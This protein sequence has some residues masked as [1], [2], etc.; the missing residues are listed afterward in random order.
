[1]LI[2]ERLSSEKTPCCYILLGSSIQ[3]VKYNAKHFLLRKGLPR[4]PDG[5]GVTAIAACRSL[6]PV[7]STG[8][9][10]FAGL[11]GPRTWVFQADQAHFFNYF[12]NSGANTESDP[13]HRRVVVETSGDVTNLMGGTSNFGSEVTLRLRVALYRGLA[14]L[15]RAARFA[16]VEMRGLEPLTPALQRRCSPN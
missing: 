4:R 12:C 8:P 9:A 2:A 5:A 3:F 11:E 14:A 1:M 7:I 15:R 6:P 13:A 10:C 16:G